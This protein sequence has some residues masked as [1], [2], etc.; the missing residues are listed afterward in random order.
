[1]RIRV[2]IEYDYEDPDAFSPEEEADY[3][4]RGGISCPELEEMEDEINLSVRAE[5]AAVDAEKTALSAA[6]SHVAKHSDLP[7]EVKETL[8]R[9]AEALR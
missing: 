8:E 2:T 1:M 3:W 7:V 5:V 4:R 6:V 9:A